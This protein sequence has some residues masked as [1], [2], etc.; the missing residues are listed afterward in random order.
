MHEIQYHWIIEAVIYH[1]TPAEL[2]KKHSFDIITATAD[3][4]LYR[5][6]V[7]QLNELIVWKNSDN[8]PVTQTEDAV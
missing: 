8:W 1:I 5:S 6:T 7:Y 2:K 4:R 3:S